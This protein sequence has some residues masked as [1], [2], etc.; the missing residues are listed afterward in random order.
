MSWQHPVPRITDDE[1][2]LRLSRLR[3][4]IE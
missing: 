4:R 3:E 1:K 2:Q